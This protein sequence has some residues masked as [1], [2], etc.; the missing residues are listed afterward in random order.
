MPASGTSAASLSI[1]GHVLLSQ[2]LF[3]FVDMLRVV[4]TSPVSPGAGHWALDSRQVVGPSPRRSI[5]YVII[6]GHVFG[7]NGHIVALLFGQQQSRS[8][9]HHS[10]A[11]S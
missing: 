10:G 9:A 5:L 3:S 8:E 2:R 6:S 4:R 7:D 1:S 11:G